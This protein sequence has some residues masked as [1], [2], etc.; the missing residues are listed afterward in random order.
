[1]ELKTRKDVLDLLASRK[2]DLATRFGVASLSLFGSAGR[3]EITAESDLDL[4]VRFSE[5]ATFDRYFGVKFYLEELT[6]RQ[7]DL[8]TEQMI[9]P[10]L[11]KR[12]EDELIDVP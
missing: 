6:G 8:A 10:R 9:K 7:V 3:D 4:V 1:M 12:I 11:R 2:E 5:S